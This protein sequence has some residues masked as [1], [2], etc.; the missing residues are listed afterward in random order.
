MTFRFSLVCELLSHLEDITCHE[1]PYT[2]Q[3]R[4]ERLLKA[5]ITWF[6]TFR[7]TID[8]L[9]A[10]GASALLSTLLP[11]R[12][13]DRTYGI[14]S[15]TLYKILGRSLGLSAS[16]RQDL[17]AY[18]TA[19]NG[20]LGSCLERILKQGGPPAMPSVSTREVD[21]FLH[22]LAG[23]S[24]FSAPEVRHKLD[25]S[26]DRT[27]ELG[28]IV[29]RLFPR[30]AKWLVR[31]ILKDHTPVVLDE[32][33][34]LRCFH[35][36]LPD[37]LNIQNSFDASLEVL[38]ETF[39][40]Y[41]S[42]PDPQSA[43]ILR[44]T[45]ATSFKPLPG[46][47]VSR[48]EFCKARSIE[49]CLRMT[50]KRKWLVERKYDGEYCQIHIDLTKGEHWLKIFSKN[51]RDSTQDRKP[52][53]D[54]IRR[55]LQ[56]GTS[57]CKIKRHCILVGEMVAYS[58]T[59]R[60]ILSFDKIRKH[61]SRAGVF[62]GA[63]QDSPVHHGE[64]LMIVFFD[65]L[66]LDEEVILSQSVEQR[67]A[68]LSGLYRKIT[69]RAMTAESRVIDF[70][71]S[72]A[73]HSLMYHFAMS[74]ASRHEGLVLKP[75]GLPYFSIP[76]SVGDGSVYGSDKVIKLKKDYISGLGDEADFAVIGA[77]YDAREA[78]KRPGL[79]L[80]WTH[81]HLGC[82]ANESE[83]NRYGV[84]PRFKVVAT[85]AF[86]QCIPPEILQR[87]N[88]EGGMY[89][90]P[91]PSAFAVV[92]DNTSRFNAYFRRPFV[93]EVL[94]SSYCKPSNADFMMLRHPRVTKLHADRTWKD[95]ISFDGLQRLAEEALTV[96]IDA[97]S[98]E[99]LLWIEKIEKSCK[100]KIALS[101]CNTTPR[102][103]ATM[104]TP[105]SRSNRQHRKRGSEAVP[106]IFV[107]AP[108][109]SPLGPKTKKDNH[110]L[111]LNMS[112][113]ASRHAFLPTPPTSSP[114]GHDATS[115]CNRSRKRPI[116]VPLEDSRKRH[117]PAIP[118]GSSPTPLQLPNIGQSSLQ[119]EM[120]YHDR[121]QASNSRSKRQ[122]LGSLADVT[123][124]PPQSMGPSLH[125]NLRDLPTLASKL[126]LPPVQSTKL[127]LT[128]S[129]KLEHCKFSVT[130]PRRRSLTSEVGVCRF[131]DGKPLGMQDVCFLSQSVIYLDARNSKVIKC[132]HVLRKHGATIIH[133]LVHWN[134]KAFVHAPLI[135]TVSE[136]QS[137]P[138]L[139]KV[140]LVD[141]QDRH[142]I[143]AV[144]TQVQTL[145]DG[146]LRERIE[147]YDY[148]IVKSLCAAGELR[149]EVDIGDSEKRELE[150]CLVGAMVFDE[151]MNYSSFIPGKAESSA[152]KPLV[153]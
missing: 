96:P 26:G 56:V 47:R 16:K 18:K 90:E 85:I 32:A 54:T 123:A 102:T 91:R 127:P 71:D 126:D 72:R 119:F 44:Q 20:D 113:V 80:H 104:P 36:L 82:L 29:L 45:A 66:L 48:S 11:Q 98:Q 34:I 133:D 70:S 65:L 88:I 84:Q 94:G 135:A 146:R 153:V 52:L 114:L 138:G 19:G 93:F 13:S 142:H 38:K 109:S 46:M 95:C 43:I 92:D 79:T 99:N 150:R 30:E 128:S 42:R 35:F 145:N 39:K 3:E 27:G 50:N 64:H 120:Q 149:D 7:S 101:S 67:K 59:E 108:D 31:L 53:H 140:V 105:G 103:D 111:K 122:R 22:D 14:Q 61:V 143:R 125:E 15:A 75:C 40:G 28:S 137:Y 4:K 121:E 118:P 110:P 21:D 147:F 117:C 9:N 69:G 62:L 151:K 24:R 68:R 33:L 2:S 17:A 6:N 51:G 63:D 1:P 37:L 77:S 86:D 87:I 144:A 41:P 132:S 141:R 115:E 78:S 139:H 76:L 124:C 10:A 136:S 5:T 89:A 23:Q 131:Q 106:T 97:E 129:T 116:E 73:K 100:T 134:R 81:F 130:E 112:S 12:R 49:T 25:L 152:D 148:N 58:D 8:S 57:K 74:I 60:R 55:A 107:D 83:V